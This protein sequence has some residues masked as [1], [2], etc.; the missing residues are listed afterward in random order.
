[1]DTSDR[2][3]DGEGA[4]AASAL[5]SVAEALTILRKRA[6]LIAGLTL[7]L[8]GMAGGYAATLAPVYEA[9]ATVLVDSRDKEIVKIDDVVEGLKTD[10]P[11]I[12]SEVEI[13][14]SPLIAGRVIDEMGL[15]DDPELVGGSGLSLKR[16]L[17][18]IWPATAG[19][20]PLEPART[21]E[22]TT[23]AA[24]RE[25]GAALGGFLSRLSTSRV[26]NTFLI[27]ITFESRD[28][29]KA[30]AIAN[31]VAEAYIAEQVDSKIKTAEIASGW[32]ERRIGELRERVFDAERLIEDH[33]AEHG[34]VDAEGFTLDEKQMARAM[35]SL[36]LA[37]AETASA[38]AKFLQARSLDPDGDGFE[39]VSDVLHSTTIGRLKEQY[40]KTTQAVADMGAKYGPR[41]PN[42][43]RATAEMQD[44]KRQ[45]GIEIRKVVQSLENEYKVAQSRESSLQSSMDAMKTGAGTTGQSTVRLRELQREAAA[46]REIYETFRK[47]VEETQ[48]QQSLQLA[49]SRVIGRAVAPGAPTGPKRLQIAV[50]GASA[51]LMLGLMLTVLLELMHPSFYRPEAIE[52]DLALRHVASLPV[53]DA[54]RDMGLSP[55]SLESIRHIVVAPQSGFAEAVRSIRVEVDGRRAGRGAD[56]VLVVSSMPNEGKSVVASNL[57]HHYA[58]SG[59]KTLLVDADLRKAMLTRSFMPGAQH[60]LLEALI[61]RASV[62]PDIVLEAATGLHFLP[63]ASEGAPAAAAA[64]LLS[65]PAMSRVLA[66]LRAE[67]EIVV[68]DCPPLMPVVDARILAD[69]ADQILFVYRHGVTP[70]PLARKALKHLDP[71]AGK[72]TGLVVNGVDPALLEAA[73]GYGYGDYAA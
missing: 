58:L 26:R 56:V 1:M 6:K 13:A 20:G 9:H 16:L 39:A 27:A 19:T 30:A 11:T 48:Q 3:E 29:A 22:R 33:K 70:R 41:H 8:A 68:I 37:R 34:I 61:E 65:S 17:R 12:E 38:K 28:P 36:V 35:E 53:L 66:A 44:A 64:E 50:L 73:G 47:R 15:H 25:A 62:R 45:L 69:L 54:P 2:D 18:R 60:G 14:R 31:A 10:T 51:G 72:I 4:P 7:V 24:G 57:A 42:M 71:N 55:R 40:A 49:D 23:A 67:F 46:A 32:L 63:A 5:P 59:M 43:M 21:L 52:R